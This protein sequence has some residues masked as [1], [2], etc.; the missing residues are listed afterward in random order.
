MGAV[1]LQTVCLIVGAVLGLWYALATLLGVAS[2]SDEALPEQWSNGKSRVGDNAWQRFDRTNSQK[3]C[4]TSIM[5]FFERRRSGK[6]D[7][8]IEVKKRK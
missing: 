7:E 2:K 3:A 8:G 1:V 5:F 6:I 4:S